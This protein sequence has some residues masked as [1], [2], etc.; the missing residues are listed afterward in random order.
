MPS[1]SKRLR[2]PLAPLLV[3][4]TLLGDPALSAPITFNTA[5]PVGTQEFV[6]RGQVVTNRSG[7]DP[8]SA[9][10]DRTVVSGIG[11]LGYGVTGQLAVFG[12]VPYVN[13]A[14]DLDAPGGRL[15]REA[16]GLGDLSLFARYTLLRRDAT[17][18]TFRIAPFA[19]L[20][21]PTGTDDER[22]TLGGV[23]ASLQPGSGALDVFGGA[24]ATYQ[25]LD[26]QLDTQ[27]AYRRNG[28]ANGFRAGDE[29]RLDGSLQYRLWPRRLG[30]GTPAFLYG[31]LE[32][33]VAHRGRNE[34][35]GVDDA[36][37]GGTMLTLTPGLQYV[38]KR[39]IIEGGVE[40]PVAQDLNGNALETDYVVR[41]G[42]RVNF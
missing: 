3:A 27:L 17:G 15:T 34:V 19:G 35:G 23:P 38:T 18:R 8:S 37:S 26:Y 13:R 20:E 24:V 33:G 2:R 5:L 28:E 36:D 6:F 1:T 22:D 42:F 39:W 32:A 31:V 30:S 41:A 14:L 40:I 16:S 10:R 25:T 4:A 11:A 21:F 9:D 7:R 12:V 29:W